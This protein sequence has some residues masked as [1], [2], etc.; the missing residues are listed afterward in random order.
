MGLTHPINNMAQPN[1]TGRWRCTAVEGAEPVLAEMGVPYLARKAASAMGYGKGKAK[2]YI[3]HEGAA[4]E[5]RSKGGRKET[6]NSFQIGLG[7]KQVIESPHG[8]KMCD[9]AWEDEV[10]VMTNDDGSASRRS[11]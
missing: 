4:F 7:Q 2:E 3:T 10:L 11:L 1:F 9:V 8:S 6:T 5:V